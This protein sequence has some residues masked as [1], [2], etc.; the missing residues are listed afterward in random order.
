MSWQEVERAAVQQGWRVERRG[1]HRAWHAPRGGIV[2]SS[3]TP[4][5]H[6]ALRNHLA[7]MRR[8]GFVV[9]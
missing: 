5:D 2:V 3:V 4:S 1:K 6:R 7:L 9:R 8:F